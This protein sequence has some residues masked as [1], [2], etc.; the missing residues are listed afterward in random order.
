MLYFK[1]YVSKDN[2]CIYSLDMIRLNLDFGQYIEEFMSYIQHLADYDFSYEVLYYPSYKAYKYRHLWS[3]TATE[4][5]C[6]W[7][8]GLDLGRSKEDV[9]LGF[10]E[11]N[12]NKCEQSKAFQKFWSTIRSQTVIRTLVR[13]DMAIDIPLARSQ[14]KLQKDGKKMYQLISKSD[15][16]TEYLGRRE[17]NG[18]VKLYDKTIESDLS[19]PLTRLELTLDKSCMP[20]DVFP[21][22]NIYDAQF[23]LDFDNDLSANDKVFVALLRNTDDYMFYFKNLTYRYRKKIEPYLAD[24]VLSLDVACSNSVRCLALSYE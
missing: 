1:S 4:D 15:G 8:L 23:G 19:Y 18:F 12:P 2:N 11:F 24:K 14:C 21:T 5:D 17:H 13:Y 7:S 22:V 9:H 20:S 16:V 10:I 6:S 3:V